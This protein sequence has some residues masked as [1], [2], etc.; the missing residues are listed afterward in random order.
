MTKLAKPI[1]IINR[2][3]GQVERTIETKEQYNLEYKYFTR[4]HD[5]ATALNV[6]SDFTGQ[7]IGK[8]LYDFNLV[9]LV[10]CFSTRYM[11]KTCKVRAK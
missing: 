7:P 6:Y 10:N 3:D 1:L 2:E 5:I 11:A 4:M 9:E 8:I